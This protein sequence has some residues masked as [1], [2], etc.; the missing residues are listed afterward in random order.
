MSK[1]LGLGM[2]YA[3]GDHENL[4]KEYCRTFAELGE[5]FGLS[6]TVGAE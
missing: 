2:P 3:M 1:Y 5:S 4:T 6:V